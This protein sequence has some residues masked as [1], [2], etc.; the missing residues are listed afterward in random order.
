MTGFLYKMLNDVVC[1][2]RLTDFYFAV[3]ASKNIIQKQG[4]GTYTL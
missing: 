3:S 4:K 1:T 2:L